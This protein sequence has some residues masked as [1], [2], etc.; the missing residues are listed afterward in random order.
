[1]VSGEEGIAASPVKWCA[2]SL[3][4][5]VSRGKRLDASVFDVEARNARI[6]LERGRYGHVQLASLVARAYYPGRFKRVYC[7]KGNGVPFYLASQI[8]SVM[9]KAEKTIST[10]TKCDIAELRL[11]PRTLLLMRSGTIGPV[12]CVSK[13]TEG[14]VF[15]DDI[16]RI[17]FKKDFDVGYVYAFLKSRPGNL[18]LATNSYGSVITH[19][20]PEH[21]SSIPIP[22]APT[23]LRRKIND[24][25][26]KSY[27]LRDESNALIDKATTM[28]CEELQLPP[29]NKFNVRLFK[30]N[31]AVDTFSVELG[32]L[33]GRLD[34]S[35]HVPIV[36]AIVEHLKRHAAEV[37]T[38]ADP[39]VSKDVILPPRFARVY[40][41]EGYGRPLVGG[42]QIHELDP[43]NKKYLS[44][45]KYGEMLSQLEVQPNTTLIT[46]SGTIGKVA[47]VPKHWNKWIPS[48]HII[49][50]V[51]AN[52]N[53]AGYLNIFLGS[54]YAHALIVRNT[55]GSVID[56]IDDAQVRSVP[57]PLLK[58]RVVQDE[59]NALALLANE[60]R[61]EAYMLEQQALLVM[62]REVLT[63]ASFVSA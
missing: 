50:I 51:P 42:K 7:Q 10:L 28:L 41:E 31:V 60:K 62:E 9:P 53:I 11:Q 27:E 57:V 43:S 29:V 25:V 17:S 22:N 8:T 44:N 1:M 6:A 4:D 33:A 15:S 19:L 39:R 37:T 20:E 14:K 54:E 30:N 47:F 46:R 18:L 45:S 32:K 52:E 59:I 12:A 23:G 3:D 21:L 55:Y 5:V 61:Y 40:V 36:K 26:M 16:I 49:R 38:V 63:I 48:D 34:A 35:Y 24:L 13:Y 2:V 58:D 56:E